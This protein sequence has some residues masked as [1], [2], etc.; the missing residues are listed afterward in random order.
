MIEM[1]GL[2][3]LP[4]PVKTRTCTIREIDMLIDKTLENENALALE[5]PNSFGYFHFSD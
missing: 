1:K 3:T 2:R 5:V 4:F